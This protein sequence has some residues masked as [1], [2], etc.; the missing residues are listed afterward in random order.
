MCTCG[1]AGGAGHET[2]ETRQKPEPEDG[3]MTDFN[4]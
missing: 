4:Q 1:W 3:S 2:G